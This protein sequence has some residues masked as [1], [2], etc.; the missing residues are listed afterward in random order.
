MELR[1]LRLQSEIGL[2]ELAN[3]I[4]IQPAYLS[5]LERGIR[6]NPTKEIMEKIAAALGKTVP[7]VFYSE[8]DEGGCGSSAKTSTDN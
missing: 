2:N 6:T 3:R 5:Q 4:G 1:K 8:I 7:E